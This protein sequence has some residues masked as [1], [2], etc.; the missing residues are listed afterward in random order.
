MRGLFGLAATAATLITQSLAVPIVAAPG[1]VTNLIITE[2]NTINGTH[3]PKFKAQAATQALAAGTPLTVSLTN[4]FS[5][6]GG[7]LYAYVNGKDM[8]GAVVMLSNSGQWYYPD[9]AGSTI[10]I[11]VEADIA[12]PLNGRGEK[13]EITIPDYIESG[14]IWVAEGELTFFT[15][16]DGNGLPQLVEPSAANPEDPSAGINWGFV[17]LTNT[18]DAGIWANISF[19]DFVGLILSMSLTLGSG[20]TQMVEGLRGDALPLICDELAAQTAIDGQP[21]DQMCVRDGS[22]NPLRVMAPNMYVASNP[23]AQDGYYDEYVEQVWAKYSAEDLIINTQAAP[24][25]VACRVDAG[26]DELRCDGD[27][28]GYP[29]PTVLDIWGCNSGPFAISAEDNAVHVAVVPRLCAAF[30]RTT[31]LAEGGNVQ[32]GPAS[33]TYYTQDPTSHYARLVHKYEVDGRGYA[34]SYDDVNPAGEN[35]AGVVSG[36]DPQVLEVFIGGTLTNGTSHR[37]APRHKKLTKLAVAV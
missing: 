33:D 9:P 18:A 3:V 17:E 35:A 28:R 36:T 7:Q 23:G 32:P 27:N 12:I 31:L 20:E 13:T 19:V 25:E 1:D 14:R 29:R 4:N 16:M 6:S 37:R 5:G 8:T 24:G 2:H 22:G 10:P 11:A 26:S 15:V 21:W 30:H 34:F